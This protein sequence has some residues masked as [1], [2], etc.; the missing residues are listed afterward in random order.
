LLVVACSSGTAE[1]NEPVVKLGTRGCTES[2]SGDLAP[3]WRDSAVTLG[4]VNFLGPVKPATGKLAPPQG[5]NAVFVK[6]LA[7]VDAGAAVEIST[8]AEGPLANS[9]VY[10]RL[11]RAQQPEPGIGDAAVTLMACPDRETQFNGGFIVMPGSV[12][13]L[14][15]SDGENRWSS[16][17][18]FQ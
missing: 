17:L 16:R 18:K 7:V 10:T 4:P 11:E 9:M 3:T 12:L 2:V 1:P 8:R 5:G 15:V 14:V 13:N 6:V